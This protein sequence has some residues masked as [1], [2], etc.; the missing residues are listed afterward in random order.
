MELVIS[1]VNSNNLEQFHK[2]VYDEFYCSASV[3]DAD[4]KNPE[5][6][7]VVT[8]NKQLSDDEFSMLAG[9]LVMLNLTVKKEG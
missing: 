8:K 3:N 6:K 1:G 9:K 5:A 7:I 4:M 2:L